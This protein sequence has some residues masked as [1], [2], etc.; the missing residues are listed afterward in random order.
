MRMLTLRRPARA[1]RR[2]RRCERGAAT[3][4]FVLWM[5]FFLGLLLLLTDVSI[6]AWRYAQ[7]WDVARTTARELSL[8]TL[9]RTQTA[10]EAFVHSRLTADYAVT[11]DGLHTTFFTVGIA[12]T[13]TTMSVFGLFETAISGMSARVSLAQ[14]NLAAG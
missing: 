4:E 1:A 9:P 3:V 7:M 10:V 6:L 5:P 2:L 8:G 13:P 14:E 12:G 11:L